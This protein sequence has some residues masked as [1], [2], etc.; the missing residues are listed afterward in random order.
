MKNL[1]KITLLFTIFFIS[2]SNAQDKKASP[3]E[4]VTGEINYARITIKYG[5]PSVKGREIWGALVP[6][7]E[8]WRA[9]ANNATTFETNKDLNIEGS[10]LPA[11][12]YTFFVIPNKENSVLIFNKVQEQWGAYKYEESKDILRITVKQKESKFN[13]EKLVYNINKDNIILSWEK[14]D[15]GFSVK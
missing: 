4:S 9:G 12:K 6:Y 10:K 14:W 15:I 13:T 1:F 7:G 3:A 2:F 5:S 8:I 11:G